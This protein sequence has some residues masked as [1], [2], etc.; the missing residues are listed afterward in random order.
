MGSDERVELLAD[1]HAEVLQA[2]LVDPLV[3][4]RDELDERDDLAVEDAERLGEDDQGDRPAVPDVL[5][6]GDRVPLEERPEVD[7]LV[8]LGDADRQVAQLVRRDVDAAR[9]EA[10]ALQGRERTV[11]A[12]EVRDRVGHRVTSGA[13]V[14]AVILAAVGS[15]SRLRCS[16]A[17]NAPWNAEVTAG[18]AP[19]ATRSSCPRSR[20]PAWTRRASSPPTW[21]GSTPPRGSSRSWTAPI[22]D[23][24]TCWKSGYGAARR[25]RSCSSAPT[26]GRWRGLGRESTTTM[27]AQSATV[28][29]DLPAAPTT[30]VVS[31]ILDALVRVEARN[32]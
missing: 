20:S 24:G 9:G 10:V 30:Q 29:L 23:S 27:L 5:A 16:P 26:S 7:V 25:S 6:I 13:I 19:P 3:D 15:T 14:R 12:D 11:V 4:G 18:C 1:D 22:R 17:R 2:H 31:A 32:P 21:A 8:P 28:R